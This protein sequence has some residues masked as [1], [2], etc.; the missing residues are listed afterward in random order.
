MHP[1][2]DLAIPQPIP[3]PGPLDPWLVKILERHRLNGGAAAQPARPDPTQW[4][5][6]NAQILANPALLG[7][8][9]TAI[10]EVL[11][12]HGL[13]LAAD[14]T[15][16]FEAVTLEQPVFGGLAAEYQ[17]GRMPAT[18]RALAQDQVSALPTEVRQYKRWWQ[19]IP[20]PEL[21]NA[22]ETARLNFLSRSTGA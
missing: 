15:Y 18:A 20:A 14:E 9:S 13:K 19:G 2:T 11:E 8:L 3:F 4:K 6:L 22:L 5:G 17:P 7:E 16:A 1:A 12:R 21:L 10:A